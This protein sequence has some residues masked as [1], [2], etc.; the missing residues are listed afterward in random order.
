MDLISKMLY[1]IEDLAEVQVIEGK[2]QRTWKVVMEKVFI[3]QQS[4]TNQ[5]K[6][7][8]DIKIWATHSAGY[9]THH[10]DHTR[11]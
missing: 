11:P 1:D 4:C 2:K 7:K 5:D 8:N 3:Q 10:A 6:M 9:E